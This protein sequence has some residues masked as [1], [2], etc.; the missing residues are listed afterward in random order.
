[1]KLALVSSILYAQ[2]IISKNDC[3]FDHL[4]GNVLSEIMIK[5]HKLQKF[6]HTLELNEF[7]PGRVFGTT[8]LE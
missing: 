8:Y 6:L 2:S 7:I 1:M 4:D 3:Y 5:R